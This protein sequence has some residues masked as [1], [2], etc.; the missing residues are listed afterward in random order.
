M[1]RYLTTILLLA[2]LLTSFS[3]RAQEGNTVSSDTLYVNF[4]E[5][6]D[7]GDILPFKYIYQRAK[8]GIGAVKDTTITSSITK[9]I[10]FEVKKGEIFAFLGPNG[11]GKSTTINI[12]TTMLNKTS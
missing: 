4:L 12:L 3:A 8:I 6:L 10:S 5:S 11:A 2:A 1:K 7:K 9:D